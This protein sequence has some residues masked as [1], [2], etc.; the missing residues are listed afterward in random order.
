MDALGE[1]KAALVV[2]AFLQADCKSPGYRK[3]LNALGEDFQLT[4]NIDLGVPA[5]DAPG[6][7]DLETDGHMSSC[8]TAALGD[9]QPS[10]ELQWP[11]NHAEAENLQQIAR[12]LR[13]IADQFERNVVAEATGNLR[14]N[15]S[16]SPS[17]EWK[18][19][20]TWEV[21]R[22]MR[23]G[24]GLEHLPQERVA[25]A[26][27]LTLVRGVCEQTPR[28]LRSLF[29]AVLQYFYPAAE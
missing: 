3:E 2:L 6:D 21:K 1:Q 28:L 19:H 24:V 7:G 9:I 22:V 29:G 15:I 16:V 26:L 12:G 18:D 10:V 8:I 13:D 23:Q 27:A 5:R 17:E 25:V 11:R 14:R 20:L 4:R